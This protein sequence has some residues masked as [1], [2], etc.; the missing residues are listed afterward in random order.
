[1]SIVLVVYSSNKLFLWLGIRKFLK[2]L[3]GLSRADIAL[4]GVNY[5]QQ[6]TDSVQV[7]VNYS[8][9]L[10]AEIKSHV[11]NSI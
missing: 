1:M 10:S 2:L 11:A 3:R 7:F 4:G 6:H 5:L 8:A 9:I